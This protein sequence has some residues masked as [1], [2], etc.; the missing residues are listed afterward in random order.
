MHWAA[1]V[2]LAKEE[3]SGFRV[4]WVLGFCLVQWFLVGLVLRVWLG[5]C[6]VAWLASPWTVIT[7]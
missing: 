5:I 4:I 2:V 1:L 7:R 6:I 3:G